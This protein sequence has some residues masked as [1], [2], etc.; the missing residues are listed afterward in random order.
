MILKK[1]VL[2]PN[3]NVRIYKISTREILPILPP[4]YTHHK[5]AMYHRN[6]EPI[7]HHDKEPVVAIK[8]PTAVVGVITYCDSN[9]ST[10]KK[11]PLDHH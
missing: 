10:L 5:E 2:T 3:P 8:H 9:F 6:K 7:H 11:S 4:H 1:S